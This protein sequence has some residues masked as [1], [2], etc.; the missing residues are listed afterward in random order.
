[1]RCLDYG[2]RAGLT[3]TRFRQ[4]VRRKSRRS[5]VRRKGRKTRTHRKIGTASWHRVLARSREGIRIW[6]RPLRPKPPLA[7][8]SSQARPRTRP[9]CLPRSEASR[10]R[11]RNRGARARRKERRGSPQA[12]GQPPRTQIEDR[13]SRGAAPPKYNDGTL[14]NLILSRSTTP[15][16]RLLLISLQRLRWTRWVDPC[17]ASRPTLIAWIGR[18]PLGR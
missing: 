7:P 2:P 1:M 13:Y 9:F 17:R 14:S 4:R 10:V 5:Q 12:V 11:L 6:L 3:M 16:E 18:S 8:A 15:C